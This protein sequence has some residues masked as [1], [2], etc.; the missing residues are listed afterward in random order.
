MKPSQA[1]CAG[2]THGRPNEAL[3]PT[4]PALYCAGPH[5]GPRGHGIL[6][7]REAGFAGDGRGVGPQ[8]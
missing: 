3:L 2:S 5:R 7:P 8:R 6:K 4:K 1:S